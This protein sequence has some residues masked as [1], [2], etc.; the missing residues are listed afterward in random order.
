LARVKEEKANLSGT[1]KKEG[2]EGRKNSPACPRRPKKPSSYRN[3]GKTLITTK[4]NKTQ[5]K[6]DRLAFLNRGTNRREN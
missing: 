5:K 6:K 4:G 2:G 3:I 1:K